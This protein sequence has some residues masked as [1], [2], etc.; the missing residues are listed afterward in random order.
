MRIEKN[1]PPE[2]AE[3]YESEGVHKATKRGAS[4]IVVHTRTNRVDVW[5]KTRKI[6][7]LR[8]EEDND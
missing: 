8:I 1:L 6:W 5:R 7:I 2:L 3:Y 4:T